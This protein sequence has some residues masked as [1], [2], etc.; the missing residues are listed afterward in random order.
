VEAETEETAFEDPV[1]Q[2]IRKLETDNLNIEIFAENY[3]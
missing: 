2:P 1:I 3:Y